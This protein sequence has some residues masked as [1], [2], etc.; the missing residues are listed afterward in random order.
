MNDFENIQLTFEY[1]GHFIS[2]ILNGNLTNWEFRSSVSL[3][4]KYFSDGILK[5]KIAF[6]KSSLDYDSFITSF[7]IQ[8]DKLLH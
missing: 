7:Y 5:P 8:A 1:K 4:M 2:G 3:F 6:K